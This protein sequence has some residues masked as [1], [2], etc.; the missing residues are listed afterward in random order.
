MSVEREKDTSKDDP[1]V[2]EKRN[3]QR[4]LR[5]NGRKRRNVG[6]WIP[7]E[8]NVSRRKVVDNLEQ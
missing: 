3:E 6:F 7:S 1:K 2:G 4:R 5:R 8:E